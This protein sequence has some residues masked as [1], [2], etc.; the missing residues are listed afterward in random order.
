MKIL[1]L[2]IDGVLNSYRSIAAGYKLQNCTSLMRE[3]QLGI[4]KS[5]GFDPTAVNLLKHAQHDIGFKIVISSTWR[6]SCNI[7]H[8][9]QIFDLY[10][11][12]TTSIII[13]ITPSTDTIRGDEIALWLRNNPEIE[14]YVILDD[15]TDFL[16]E[17]IENC[18]FT[19]FEEGLTYATFTEIYRKFGHPEPF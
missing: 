13:D 12:D 17:Q 4:A 18:V 1:F 6:F 5:A 7:N 10:D 16:K 8:F 14:S 2:D 9:H 15:S 3:M 19:K 11:W